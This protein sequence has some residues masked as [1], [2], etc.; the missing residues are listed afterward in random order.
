M[1]GLNES[2]KY[3]F[4]VG[5]L[6]CLVGFEK[7]SFLYSRSLLKYNW[8]RVL[9]SKPSSTSEHNILLMPWTKG[10]PLVFNKCFFSYFLWKTA[11]IILY[12]PSLISIIPHYCIAVSYIIL[13]AFS[14]DSCFT[15]QH[16]KPYSEIIL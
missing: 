4:I 7:V 1:D 14:I 13:A 12:C 15:L 16:Y 2:W 5:Q 8:I 11:V 6:C 10:G 9:K 3:L